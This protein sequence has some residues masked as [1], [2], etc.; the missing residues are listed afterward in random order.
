ML[1][2]IANLKHHV[3]AAERGR[4]ALNAIALTEHGTVS[5][6]GKTLLFIPYPA[7]NPKDVP[8][9]EGIDAASLPA[10][11]PVLI[12]VED[13]VRAAS[14]VPAKHINPVY[15]YIQADFR[16]G[17]VVFAGTDGAS[18][19]QVN[20]TPNDG[21]YPNFVSVL[22][23]YSRSKPITL[24][25]GYLFKAIKTLKEASGEDIVTLRLLDKDSAVNISTRDGLAMLVMPTDDS[26]SVDGFDALK[27]KPQK[28]KRERKEK[29]PRQPSLMLETEPTAD[30][31]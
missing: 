17:K 22:P 5:S 4:W 11:F 14:I 12:N 20:A 29:K 16:G 13:A 30:E 9:I 8:V 31:A 7:V 26:A 15:R 19:Q 27:A 1:L 3:A 21:E 23:D 6:N 24:D 18:V 10:T 28:V 2:S 25:V